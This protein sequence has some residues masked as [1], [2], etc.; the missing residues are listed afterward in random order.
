MA[1]FTK[2][3]K[4][5]VAQTGPCLARVFSREESEAFIWRCMFGPPPA[6]TN[7]EIFSVVLGRPVS[8]REF[9]TARSMGL[10]E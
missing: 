2:R 4:G 3:C 6:D 10:V 7:R 9:D 5:M 8:A 1:K